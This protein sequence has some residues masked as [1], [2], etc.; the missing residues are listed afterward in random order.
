MKGKLYVYHTLQASEE[1]G[2]RY[3]KTYTVSHSLFS[4]KMVLFLI[5]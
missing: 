4:E 3:M 2:G 5:F 1:D